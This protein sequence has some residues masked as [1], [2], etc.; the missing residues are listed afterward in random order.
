MTTAKSKMLAC[1]DYSNI[2]PRVVSVTPFMV[3]STLDSV[4]ANARIRAF[5]ST[6]SFLQPRR[7]YCIYK[8]GSVHKAA[9]KMNKIHLVNGKLYFQVNDQI[10]FSKE[11]FQCFSYFICRKCEWVIKV[12]LCSR[13]TLIRK[14]SVNWAWW[15]NG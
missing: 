3:P 15:L 13:A 2:L 14:I 11:L 8:K 4:S 10:Y 6:L 9:F 1:N 7:H 12:N 5:C